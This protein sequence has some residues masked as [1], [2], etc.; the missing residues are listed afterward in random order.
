MSWVFITPPQRAFFFSFHKNKYKNGSKTR[1]WYDIYSN[2][3]YTRAR[4]HYILDWEGRWQEGRTEWDGGE[5]SPALIELFENPASK[6]LIPEG[7]LGLVPGCG[8]GMIYFI[9]DISLTDF[10]LGY[11]VVFLANKD[12]HVIGMDF[13]QTCADLLEKVNK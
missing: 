7:G 13:S 11:D 10:V 8:S 1:N 2:T 3:L 12:R 9:E 4:T 5:P 6:P